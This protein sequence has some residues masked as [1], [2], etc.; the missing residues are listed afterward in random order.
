MQ[1]FAVGEQVSTPMLKAQS[2]VVESRED[3][4]KADATYSKHGVD[5]MVC[6]GILTPEMFGLNHYKFDPTNPKVA[7]GIP[8]NVMTTVVPVAMKNRTQVRNG[9]NKA[10]G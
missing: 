2:D 9:S 10:K 6:C 7:D 8:G 5:V 1:E 4:I 3:K